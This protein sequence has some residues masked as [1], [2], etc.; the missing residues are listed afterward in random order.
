[1]SRHSLGSSGC[2]G[3]S[4]SWRIRRTDEENDE[5]HR[6]LEDGESL[7]DF[8]RLAVAKEIVRR[9]RKR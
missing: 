2:Q 7:S 9:N 8:V 3:P 4:K 5:V 6:L 1:M